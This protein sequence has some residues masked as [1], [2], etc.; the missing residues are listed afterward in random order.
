M[1]S[2][3]LVI[4]T[5]TLLH[6]TY[7]ILHIVHSAWYIVRTYLNLIIRVYISIK[8]QCIIS[9]I[10]CCHCQLGPLTIFL[11]GL[12]LTGTLERFLCTLERWDVGT[13]GRWDVGT[14]G[15]WD[16]VEAAGGG[17]AGK[18]WAVTDG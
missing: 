11:E 10:T 12:Q 16:V 4:S 13:L 7:N 1:T 17:W 3:D 8:E 5:T 15:R 14:L 18:T 6:I 9:T 2:L